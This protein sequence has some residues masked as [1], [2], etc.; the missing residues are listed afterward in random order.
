MSIINDKKHK[1]MDF[2]IIILIELLFPL[3]PKRCLEGSGLCTGWTEDPLCGRECFRGPRL[4]CLAARRSWYE[5]NW[6]KTLQCLGYFWYE[7]KCYR[8]VL[9]SMA[10][11]VWRADSAIR[12]SFDK[13]WVMV[14]YGLGESYLLSK[15][16]SSRG[17]TLHDWVSS[18]SYSYVEDK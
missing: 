4:P 5:C 9:G 13:R 8:L 7:W 10:C 16:L 17:R 15:L 18:G 3:F 14:R 2:C 6:T 11:F 12:F 1:T